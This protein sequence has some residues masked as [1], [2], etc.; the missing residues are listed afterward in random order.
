MISIA[1]AK[2]HALPSTLDARRAK[3]RKASLTTQKKSLDSSCSLSFSFCVSIAIILWLAAR[4]LETA[5][6][7]AGQEAAEP[8]IRWPAIDRPLTTENQT[9]H[10]TDPERG[11]DRLRRVLA[12][13]LLAVV[14]K[15]ADA[16][17]RIIPDPFRAAQI[18]T[19][20]CACGRAEIFSRFAGVRHATL[21]FFSRLRRNRRALIH[22]VFVS[23]KFPLLYDLFKLSVPTLR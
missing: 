4:K 18:F 11:K 16:M 13:V 15:T 9:E 8:H 14:L 1:P 17:E 10:E 2:A 7:R 6:L 19:G 20:H 21:C 22:L 23:H 5:H 12:N 3:I